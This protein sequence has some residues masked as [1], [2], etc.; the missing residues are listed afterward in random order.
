MQRDGSLLVWAVDRPWRRFLETDVLLDAAAAP[1]AYR[2]MQCW[3]ILQHDEV[4]DTRP[5]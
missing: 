3:A 1:P 4:E 2:R 5:R